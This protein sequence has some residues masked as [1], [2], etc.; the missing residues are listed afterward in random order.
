MFCPIHPPKI[1]SRQNTLSISPVRDAAASEFLLIL[2]LVDSEQLGRYIP[3]KRLPESTTTRIASRISH[4]RC[5]PHLSVVRFPP[6]L[7]DRLTLWTTSSTPSREP[8]AAEKPA[9]SPHFQEHAIVNPPCPPPPQITQQAIYSRL[10]CSSYFRP[11]SVDA[12]ASRIPYDLACWL[13]SNHHLLSKAAALRGP[14]S[15]QTAIPCLDLAWNA[16]LSTR[17]PTQDNP[18]RHILTP[19]TAQPTNPRMSVASRS[20][21]RHSTASSTVVTFGAAQPR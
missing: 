15:T 8:Y 20:H 14:Q 16:H 17:Q 1:L 12:T 13:H 10:P 4:R 11:L 2:F 7:L 19:A 5:S 18:G 6:R 21:S 3:V 9:F